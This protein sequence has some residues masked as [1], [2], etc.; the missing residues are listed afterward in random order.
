MKSR[1]SITL[2]MDDEVESVEIF[3][4]A[5]SNGFSGA[6]SA[7]FARRHIENVATQLANTYPLPQEK[8]LELRSDHWQD[9]T[10]LLAEEYLRLRFYPVGGRGIVACQ[11][12]LAAWPFGKDRNEARQTVSMELLFTYDALRAFA[13]ALKAIAKNGTSEAVLEATEH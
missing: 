6:A 3:A 7:W 2:G 1:L 5:R 12:E 11:V 9:S 4:D 10:S 13:L 8:P